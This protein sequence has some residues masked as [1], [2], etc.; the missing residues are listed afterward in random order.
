MRPNPELAMK[1]QKM[2]GGQVSAAK[3]IFG[4]DYGEA[5]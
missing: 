1:I 3:L 5:E 2:S 4:D